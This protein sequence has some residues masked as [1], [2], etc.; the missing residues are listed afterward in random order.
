MR[1]ASVSPSGDGQPRPHAPVVA[2]VSVLNPGRALVDDV[3]MASVEAQVGHI[4]RRLGFGPTK[5]DITAGVR[6]GTTGLIEKF[7][8]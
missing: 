3:R 1:I 8:A 7:L 2:S 4:W 5:A 6:L